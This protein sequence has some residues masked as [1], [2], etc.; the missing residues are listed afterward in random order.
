MLGAICGDIIGSRFEGFNCKRKDFEL[1]SDNCKMTDDSIMTLAIADAYMN[2]KD[3]A[4]TIIKYARENPNAGYGG[5]FINWVDSADHKPYNSWGNGSAMR[6]SALSWLIDDLET[7][8]D[9]AEKSAII[10]HNHPEGIKGAQA[11][12]VSVWMARRGENKKKIKEAIEVKFGYDLNRTVKHL[13]EVYEFDVSCQGSVPEAIIC[14]LESTDVEDCIRTAI[15]IGGDSD[16]IASMATAIAEAYYLNV[17]IE[18]T[19]YVVKH[20]D[21]SG[22]RSVFDQFNDLITLKVK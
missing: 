1:F 22:Y 16:T 6:V 8:L 20:I 13:Q 11:I 4:E 2:Q 18:L 5:S 19:E 7:L 17:P 15:S 21:K 10:T 3:Y 9:E 12:A 14:F